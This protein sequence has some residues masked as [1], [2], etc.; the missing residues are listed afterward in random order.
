MRYLT[1]A[2]LDASTLEQD[3]FSRL[4]RGSALI[5]HTIKGGT[6]RDRV[7]GPGNRGNSLAGQT[8][9]HQPA[10]GNRGPEGFHDANLIQDRRFHKEALILLQD[11]GGGTNG[12]ISVGRVGRCD[13]VVNDYS[14]SGIHANFVHQI[15]GTP[16]QVCDQGSRNGTFLNGEKLAAS[17]RSV[18][19]FDIYDAL[20]KC[21][22]FIEQFGGH[23]YAAGLTLKPENYQ[24]FKNRFEKVVKE[25]IPE[26]SRIPRIKIDAE[27]FLEEITPKFYR[28][29][30]QF[31][32]FGPGNMKPVFA[33][34]GLRDNG[35]GKKVGSDEDHLKLSIVSGVDKKTY[36]AIGFGLGDKYP[37]IRN[38]AS[39]KAAFTVEENHWNGITSIQLNVKDLK[40]E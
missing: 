38:G 27:L 10:S 34:S 2:R 14:V 15:R 8:L 24:N 36:Q 12:T 11:A 17:A 20:T 37:L 5:L 23:K 32:P 26:K 33:S 18:S 16:A 30:K 4:Y 13:V 1:E 21:S 22:E 7:G 29:L 25:T 40:E 28:I 9:A 35:Y 39:F 31:G 3:A 6:L 19:G